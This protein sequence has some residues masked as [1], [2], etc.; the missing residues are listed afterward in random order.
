MRRGCEMSRPAIAATHHL[1][2]AHG[3]ATR[4][5]RDCAAHAEIGIVLNGGPSIP[6]TSSASDIKAAKQFESEQ[7]HRYACPIF[8]G[9]YPDEFIAEVAGHIQEDDLNIIAQSI[10]YLG[11]NYYT[12][13]VVTRQRRRCAGTGLKR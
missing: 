3:L 12:R 2:L 4:A 1:L 5:L 10:D 6:L 7:L 11:W 9:T 13:N 8:A